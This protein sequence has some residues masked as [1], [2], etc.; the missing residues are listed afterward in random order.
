MKNREIIIYPTIK[1]C[2]KC[3]IEKSQSYFSKNKTN[4]SGLSDTCKECS[5]KYYIKNK[6]SL[7]LK[8]K[9]LALN[10]KRSSPLL[11]GGWGVPLPNFFIFIWNFSNLRP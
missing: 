11:K 1:I 4:K 7:L 9:V 5:Q 10:K 2:S 8:E 3:K 6:E